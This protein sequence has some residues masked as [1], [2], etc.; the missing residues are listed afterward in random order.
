MSPQ[1]PF[2][3][4]LFRHDESAQGVVIHRDDDGIN[5]VNIRL[6]RIKHGH[7]ICAGGF[8]A[9]FSNPEVVGQFIVECTI[10]A[11]ELAEKVEFKLPFIV[12]NSNQ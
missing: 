8:V 6:G 3:S 5:T 10:T 12:K 7:E 2:T 4:G 9:V 1:L 11:S